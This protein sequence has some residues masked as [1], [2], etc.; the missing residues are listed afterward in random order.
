[1]IR[2]TLPVIISLMCVGS[3]MLIESQ[4]YAGKKASRQLTWDRS[5]PIVDLFQGMESGR[6]KVQMSA[7]NAN[8]ANLLVKNLTDQPLT[9]SVPKA[10]VGVP[11]LPQFAVPAPA[12]G[13]A[14]PA[15]GP[16]NQVIG[17]NVQG[18]GERTQMVGGQ[19]QPFGNQQ[20]GF[21][22]DNNNQGMNGQG[23][24]S[25]PPERAVQLRMRTVCLDYG[26]PEPHLGVNYELRSVESVS[27]NPVLR[28]LLEGY[29]TRVNQ[30]EMQAAAWHLASDLSWKQIANLP[31]PEVPFGLAPM[32]T[33]AQV[34]SAQ[35]LVQRA[36]KAAES[37]EQQPANP[38]TKP[39][40][41]LVTTKTRVR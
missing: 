19:I 26:L 22:K 16:L 35:D 3:W 40:A 17:N 1:M 31:N 28:Q 23:L 5:A 27:S 29:S 15:V 32:F 41:K 6:I 20:Q 21:P 37:E 11:I 10:A 36:Q 9:V 39:T 24:F 25:I 34:E 8:T 14:N 4:A 18:N 13:N 7:M 30:T 38:P 2:R 12:N 33:P